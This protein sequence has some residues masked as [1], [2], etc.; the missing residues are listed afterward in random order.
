MERSNS[1]AMTKLFHPIQLFVLI[2]SRD[3]GV[4]LLLTGEKITVLIQ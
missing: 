3:I 4:G 2:S 1:R